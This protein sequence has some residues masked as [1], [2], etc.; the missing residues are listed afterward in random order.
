MSFKNY[1]NVSLIL[2]LIILS[3]SFSIIIF[4]SL[5]NIYENKDK[6]RLVIKGVTTEDKPLDNE[7]YTVDVSKIDLAKEIINKG[8]YI[9]YFRHAHREKWI[10]VAMYDAIEALDN[11]DARELYFKKAVCLSDMGLIQAQMMGEFI[12][13]IN[14]P[15]GHIITSPSCRARETSKLAFGQ[16]GEIENLLLHPGPFNEKTSEFQNS[17]KKL[18]LEI[19]IIDG[20]NSIVSAHNG[21]IKKSIFDEF[22]KDILN[23]Y[24]EEGGFYVI[25]K[26]KEKLTLV[27]KFHSFN[28]FNQIFFSRPN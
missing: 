11:L 22:D 23:Y 3:I 14:L 15:I 12:K 16:E 26:N 28:D 20:K 24:L 21:V 4:S 5:I 7:G 2:L 18:L 27:D 10:D 1:K 17:I 19:P 9:L 13:K 8:G 25:R 6:I